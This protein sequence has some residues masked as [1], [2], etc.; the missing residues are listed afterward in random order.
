MEIYI[1]NLSPQA[2]ASDLNKLFGFPATPPVC[3]IF[4][5]QDRD[6]RE[7]CYALAIIHPDAAGERLIKRFKNAT[8]NGARLNVRE[9]EPRRIG[10]ERRA[11]NWRNKPW[12]G[13]VRRTL[14]R[15][16]S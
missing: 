5:K 4:K 10:N 8:L 1:G 7:H 13:P 2:T 11:L 15:R 9:H 14:E 6:G 16:V 12:A 3:R